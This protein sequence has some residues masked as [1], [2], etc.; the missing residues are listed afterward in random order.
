MTRFTQTVG[1]KVRAAFLPDEMI[2]DPIIFRALLLLIGLAF[3][4]SGLIA[5]F[6]GRFPDVIVLHS[7]I[8]FGIDLIGGKNY[9]LVV[10]AAAFGLL[11]SHL[12]CTR[13]LYRFAKDLARVLMVSTV[14]LMI[15]LTVNTYFLINLNT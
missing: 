14:V 4:L 15:F 12:L 2:H 1:S 5:Y 9:S 11:I 6:Y 13:A 7:N 3:L 10:P 8:Y